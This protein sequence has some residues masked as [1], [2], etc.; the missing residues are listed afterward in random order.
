MENLIKSDVINQ[1]FNLDLGSLALTTVLVTNILNDNV[2]VDYLNSSPDR[3]EIFTL[4]D[5]EY[6]ASIKIID[7]LSENHDTNNQYSLLNNKSKLFGIG[8]KKLNKNPLQHYDDLNTKYE[9]WF[10]GFYETDFVHKNKRNSDLHRITFKHDNK[11]IHSCSISIGDYEANKRY[12]FN[13]FITGELRFYTTKPSSW[14][15]DI[16]NVINEKTTAETKKLREILVIND[17]IK[18]IFLDNSYNINSPYT[19]K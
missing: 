14:E 5:F 12:L 11:E 13:D 8:F 7:E 15:E 6:F 2:Y 18:N 17:T 16:I 19:N 9:F 3:K 10:S 4:K 1:T